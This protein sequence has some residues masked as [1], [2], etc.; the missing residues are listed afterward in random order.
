MPGG[1]HEPP[2][3]SACRQQSGI[4][5]SSLPQRCTKGLKPTVPG[6]LRWCFLAVEVRALA[7]CLL[8]AGGVCCRSPRSKSPEVLRWRNAKWGSCCYFPDSCPHRAAGQ[9]QWPARCHLACAETVTHGRGPAEQGRAGREEGEGP[10]AT[11]SL[12]MLSFH[13]GIKLHMVTCTDGSSG[14]GGSCSSV[15]SVG[16]SVVMPLLPYTPIFLV[17]LS[18]AK[19]RGEHCEVPHTV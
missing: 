17:F 18:P 14:L 7:G 8:A 15:K 19:G 11:T 10:A 16:C 13:A 1:L 5:P 12:R 2:A 9:L 6:S 3:T 4:I